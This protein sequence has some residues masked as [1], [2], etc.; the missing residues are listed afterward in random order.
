MKVFYL[1]L[2]G[3]DMS[4]GVLF[5]KNV[6]CNHEVNFPS[7]WQWARDGA[8]AAG[9]FHGYGGMHFGIIFR[10]PYQTSNTY[11]VHDTMQLFHMTELDTHESLMYGLVDSGQAI[12]IHTSIL[13]T[14]K[15]V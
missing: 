3:S 2:V 1:N 11:N 7:L 6:A 8:A 14:S 5:T 15:W 10:G 12:H 4:L 9:C 13:Q